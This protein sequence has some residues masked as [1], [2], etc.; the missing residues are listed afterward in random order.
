MINFDENGRN[1]DG[2][3]VAILLGDGLEGQIDINCRENFREYLETKYPDQVRFEEASTVGEIVI[4]S[5]KQPKELKYQSS[6]GGEC[7]MAVS[8]TYFSLGHD[9]VFLDGKQL[10]DCYPATGFSLTFELETPKEEIIERFKT[11]YD[12][13]PDSDQEIVEVI[14]TG[15]L[16]M[17][18]SDSTNLHLR[19]LNAT[20]VGDAV[21]F[22]GRATQGASLGS[23][24]AEKVQPE[25]LLHKVGNVT[26]GKILS[27]LLSSCSRKSGEENLGERH[28]P[29]SGLEI[30][31]NFGGVG[32]TNAP[33]AFS[34]FPVR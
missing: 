11:K 33:V 24:V 10:T 15:D 29:F 34:H 12:R 13:L 17:P 30:G 16:L 20:V 1:P 7:S 25:A 14:R 23:Y 19:M 22:F 6:T 32:V 5:N 9:L 28:K 2:D 4:D 8:E 27:L 18:Y 21:V 26:N 3:Y 31:M